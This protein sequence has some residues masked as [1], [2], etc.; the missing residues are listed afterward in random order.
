MNIEDIRE[1][2]LTKQQVSE[3]LPFGPDTLVFKVCG[4]V[5]LLV[6]LDQV[7][8]LSFNVKCD[9]DV[10]IE[11]RLNYSE[12][13]IPGYHMNKKHWNTVYCNRQLSDERLRTFIDDSYTLV[14]NSLPK[15]VKATLK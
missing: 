10:A 1:Y 13:V 6:G 8:S 14:C 4:K 7:E 9:P 3:E 2:C 12:T 5:F 11:L 15:A